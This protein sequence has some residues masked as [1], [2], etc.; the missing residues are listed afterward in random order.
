MSK[1]LIPIDI[2]TGRYLQVDVKRLMRVTRTLLNFIDTNIKPENDQFQILKYVRPLCIST[3]TGTIQLPYP[4][5]ELPLKHYSREG[6]LPN[7]FDILYADFKITIS[8]SPTF[9]S[10][11]VNVIGTICKYADFED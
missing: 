6:M 7:D 4:F 11:R 2:E 3:L 8:G 10:E 9:F 5:S 1:K